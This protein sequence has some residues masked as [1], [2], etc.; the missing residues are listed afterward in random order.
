MALSLTNVPKLDQRI[1]IQFLKAEGST[2]TE[3]CRRMLPV[4]GTSCVASHIISTSTLQSVRTYLRATSIHSHLSTRALNGRRFVSDTAVQD[5]VREWLLQQLKV[6][7]ES[8]INRLI[9]QWE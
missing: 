8:G 3:I 9:G 2:P 4:Y 5:S 6:F 1:V 7:Y